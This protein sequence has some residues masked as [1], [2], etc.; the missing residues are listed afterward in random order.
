MSCGHLFLRALWALSYNDSQS[1]QTGLEVARGRLP[2][3]HFSG[4]LSKVAV[5]GIT[6]DLSS[7]CVDSLL[8]PV[9]TS[10]GA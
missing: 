1:T 8:R 9:L 6:A 3:Q 7:I 2:R 10:S 4:K 5:S